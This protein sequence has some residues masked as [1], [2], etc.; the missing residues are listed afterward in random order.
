MH[1]PLRPHV[2]DW[3]NCETVAKLPDGSE[4]SSFSDMSDAGWQRVGEGGGECICGVWFDATECVPSSNR[5][6]TGHQA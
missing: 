4:A 2:L 3:Q 5:A 1:S 6:S